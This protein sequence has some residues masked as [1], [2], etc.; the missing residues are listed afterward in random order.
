MSQAKIRKMNLPDAPKPTKPYGGGDPREK[1]N[2][3]RRLEHREIVPGRWKGQHVP[4]WDRARVHKLHRLWNEGYGV[5]AIMREIAAPN[6]DV[7]RNRLRYDIKC[8]KI[9]PRRKHLTEEEI[10]KV[11]R[12]RKAGMDCVQIAK[13]M[14]FSAYGIR[15]VIKR[16][17]EKQK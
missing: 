8:G 13:E 10:A 7:V 16:V 6:V 4:F 17:E 2:A 14:R 12:M 11:M 15:K 3:Q 1:E 5:K 9:Q